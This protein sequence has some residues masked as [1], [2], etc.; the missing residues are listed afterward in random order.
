[1][2]LL[3]LGGSLPDER[4]GAERAGPG[5]S[6]LRETALADPTTLP[7][8]K[9]LDE[10][11]AGSADVVLVH[12]AAL[13]EPYGPVGTLDPGAIATAVAVNLTAP[14]LITNALF[15]SEPPPSD[16][17]PSDAPPSD[18]PPSDAPPSDAPPNDAPDGT[19]S[20]RA[21]TVVF[22]S[23]AAAHRVSGGRSVYSTTKRAGETFFACL[24][25][26]RAFD[27]RIRCV[28]VDPGIMDTG[29]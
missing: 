22:I 2:G 20:G 16:A 6:G 29:M 7:S 8:A 18:A 21:V 26:E 13:F 4:R 17:P 12:N 27:A 19:G 10:F 5:R 9:E 24:S 15:P 3:S 1:G 28:I 11:L 23:S 25:D 14:I